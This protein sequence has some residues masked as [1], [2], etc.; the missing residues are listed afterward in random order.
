MFS[1]HTYHY[2]TIN[3]DIRS[4]SL[5]ILGGGTCYISAGLEY[6]PPDH[7]GHHQFRW[8][9]GRVLSEYQLVYITRGGGVFESKTGGVRTINSGDLFIL[10]PNEWHRYGPGDATGW[11]ENWVAFNGSHAGELI[12]QMGISPANPIFRTDITD[13]LKRE[14][15]RIEEELS[16]EAAG[17][18]NI[19]AAR[20]E[21]ILALVTTYNLR[22]NHEAADEIEV[23]KRAKALLVEQIDR[24]TGIEDLAK[25]LGVGYSWFRKAFRQHV[26]ISPGEY[27]RQVRISRASEL[28][29]GSSLPIAE[30]GIRCGFESAYYFSRIFRK[31][32]GMTPSEYRFSSLPDA[33]AVST[34]PVLTAG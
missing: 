4:R 7:P 15:G 11:D 12:E 8:H 24:T 13:S 27:Q 14:F 30:I 10:F 26:G 16:N 18:Q 22:S 28:L 21:L 34:R 19:V 6:P 20:I 25:E 31:K 23:I 1:Q 9:H 2:L 32:T 29:R 33:V 5:Y 17:Y 3:E